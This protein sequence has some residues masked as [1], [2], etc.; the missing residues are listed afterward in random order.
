MKENKKKPEVESIYYARD[1]HSH[2]QPRYHLVTPNHKRHQSRDGESA[3]SSRKGIE[4]VE[5]KKSKRK[6]HDDYGIWVAS[7]LTPELGNV[8]QSTLRRKVATK[9]TH[10][11]LTNS[12]R[13]K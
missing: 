12:F 3:K 5:G 4:R 11:S 7:K 1:G 6:P 2:S 8:Q 9:R 13:G 10:L